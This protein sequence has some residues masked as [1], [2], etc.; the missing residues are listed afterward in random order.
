MGGGGVCLVPA[1]T[2]EQAA[3]VRRTQYRL[4]RYLSVCPRTPVF[5]A[6]ISGF[7]ID[8][9]TQTYTGLTIEAV[10]LGTMATVK[11]GLTVDIG[12]TPG[13]RDVGSL[14]VRT[15]GTG[16]T[17]PIAE[18]GIG[19]FKRTLS[20]GHYVTVREE[21]RLWTRLP[22]I[23]SSKSSGMSYFDTFTVKTDYDLAYTDQN[24]NYRPIANVTGRMADWVDEGQ[25]YRSAALYA[26][27]PHDPD[28]ASVALA[29]GASIVSYLWDAADGTFAPDYGDSDANVV[30]Q[31]P[32]GFR[33][34]SLTVTDDNGSSATR[35]FP[36]WAHDPSYPP[37]PAPLGFIVDR[38]ETSMTGGREMDVTLFG[39]VDAAREGVIGEG[40]LFCYW[41]DVSFGYDAPP[42]PYRDQFM[43]W[44]VSDSTRLQL[45]R[46]A[47]LVTL[48]GPAYWL[49]VYTGIQ[50]TFLRRSTP[51]TW[52]QMAHVTDDRVAAFV[53]R[54]RATALDVCNLYLSGVTWEWYQPEDS[55]FGA[56]KLNKASLL[57][58]LQ[59][60]TA[61]Y[62]GQAGVDS[63]GGIWL[64][65]NPCLMPDLLDPDRED[66]TTVL[67]VTPA[68]TTDAEAPV[69]TN[70]FTPGV[71]LVDVYGAFWTGSQNNPLRA[72]A[73][74]AA[75]GMALAVERVPDQVLRDDSTQAFAAFHLADLAGLWLA[76]LNNPRKD[77][78]LTLLGDLDVVE[79]A[80]MEWLA[81]NGTL[82]N[83][84]GLSLDS[85]RWLVTQV[86]IQHSAEPPF[87]RITWT[88]AQE[89]TGPSGQVIPVETS[90]LI[91][92]TDYN[93]FDWYPPGPYNPGQ[94]NPW[95]LTGGADNIAAFNTDGYLYITHD[96]T[97]PAALGGPTWSR[98]QISTW[99]LL[100]FVVDAF[101]PFYLTAGDE[102]NG[103][104]C[105]EIGIYRIE[106][107]FNVG[108]GRTVTLQKTLPTVIFD[109]GTYSENFVF[110][111]GV[112]S[113]DA[114]FGVQNH[115]V[116]CTY[117][118]GV[119]VKVT[120]TTDG[121]T[122]S[123]ETLVVGNPTG[124]SNTR[125]YAPG[126]YVSSKTGGLVV[127]S[128]FSVAGNN[129]Q[130][131]LS[132]DYGATWVKTD[133]SFWPAALPGSRKLLA[134]FHVPWADNNDGEIVYFTWTEDVG[135][136]N[137][138]S[139]IYRSSVDVTPVPSH[140]PRSMSRWGLSTSFSNRL[141]VATY[142]Q[143]WEHRLY[144]SE[145]GGDSWVRKQPFGED[146]I[147]TR[148][149]I[150]GDDDDCV[151]LFGLKHVT[152]AVTTRPLMAFSNDF[153]TTVDDRSGN[154]GSLKT[155]DDQSQFVGI[156]G[157]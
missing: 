13:A 22:V 117:Y 47:Y 73:P 121:V 138:S 145:N 95:I 111:N 136:G 10:T 17:I 12:T 154:L 103:W 29:P 52:Y 11:A 54:Y 128:G 50:E 150:A 146:H 75:P 66:V 37:L 142:V 56:A 49:N 55:N 3:I 89:T 115:V 114:S 58:Q 139:R 149:A 81:F 33:Y 85:T 157:G 21:R 88:L 148:L 110:N 135:G 62:S 5:Q 132:Y 126:C 27:P 4:R 30:I 130:F 72:K 113:M 122:W 91:E 9:W 105:T 153:L 143:N 23:E 71:G 116:C 36:V 45:H 109:T 86:S 98:T 53:L 96:Y 38:D 28:K 119:G 59:A 93:P 124:A 15:D 80:R 102:V 46:S 134:D 123:A 83:V 1:L 76:W 92:E 97:T 118:G 7:V 61:E 20:N 19:G 25:A 87:K 68:D 155:W 141:K 127:T 60:L 67:T 8:A 34:V 147:Y 2:A 40:T 99:N 32:P 41:E 26:N 51:T 65:R 16:S 137:W 151:Y 84:R 43:G 24:E 42:A 131:Y 107:I 44:S 18:T 100:Q 82:P 101:S 70:D 35:Y 144:V 14:R 64:R 74:G 120:Y 6:T 77:V 106:D 133:G 90:D 48:G 94:T 104:F 69:A 112:R 57:A 79:P 31:F 108:T 156:C 78:P 39:E 129:A 152:G 63:E 140:A 125:A